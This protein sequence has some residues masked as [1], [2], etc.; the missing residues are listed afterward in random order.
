MGGRF[1]VLYGVVKPAGQES[2]LGCGWGCPRS[3]CASRTYPTE[4]VEPVIEGDLVDELAEHTQDVN[5]GAV[6][7]RLGKCPAGVHVGEVRSMAELS[8]RGGGVVRRPGPG[9]IIGRVR[10]FT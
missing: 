7:D 6:V 3:V 9:E 2:F 1:R 4:V 5:A 10:R 8:F